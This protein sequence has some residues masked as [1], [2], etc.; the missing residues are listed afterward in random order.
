[1]FDPEAA[2]LKD[3]EDEAP[4]FKMPGFQENDI[5]YILIEKKNEMYFFFQL[6][7]ILKKILDVFF[8]KI[9]FSVCL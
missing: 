5:F 6:E 9:P 7:N 1:M 8:K 4:V 3:I 2:T